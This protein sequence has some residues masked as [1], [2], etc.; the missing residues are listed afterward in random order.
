MAQAAAIIAA[1]GTVYSGF[2]QYQSSRYQ[3]AVASNNARLAKANA[4]RASDAAQ[5]EQRRSDIEYSATGGTVE[6]AQSVSG[7]DTLGRSQLAV[8]NRTARAGR[9]A[10]QDIRRQG[11]E[12][13]RG[14]FQQEQSFRGQA[15]M[16]K[17]DAGIALVNIPF[18]LAGQ[19]A[20][21]GV[22]DRSTP[23]QS[24]AGGA[25]STRRGRHNLSSGSSSRYFGGGY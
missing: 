20:E 6:A 17:R 14:L 16:H 11:E 7:L 5:E 19:A 8:R 21:M 18:K 12:Q 25:S 13:V 15:M 3:A 4:E 1:V 22:F 2:T 10:A 24:L 9:T 23:D